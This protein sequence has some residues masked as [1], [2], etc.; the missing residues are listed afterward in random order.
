MPPD[1]QLEYYNAIRHLEMFSPIDRWS[2]FAGCGVNDLFYASLTRI[3]KR[4][5]S[6]DV[7]FPCVLKAERHVDKQEFLKSQHHFGFLVADVKDLASHAAVNLLASTTERV[8]LPYARMTDGGFPC[9]SR[10]PL[11]TKR[12][13]N[14]NCVQEQ[15]EATGDGFG[16]AHACAFAHN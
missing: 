7:T 10:T 13:S 3:W 9:V 12:Q 11:S 6:I 15:R 2:L 4:S 8:L 14:V 16:D 1:L 5:Y